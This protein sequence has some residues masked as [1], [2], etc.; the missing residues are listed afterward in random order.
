MSVY[1]WGQIPFV[2]LRRSN[3]S[4][5]P[6]A[7]DQNQYGTSGYSFTNTN[8]F[9]PTS[10]YFAAATSYFANINETGTS[11]KWLVTP[12]ISLTGDNLKLSL[13][14]MSGTSS[15]NYKDKFRVLFTTEPV[16]ETLNPTKFEAFTVRNTVLETDSV[17]NLAPTVPVRYEV[18]L[19]PSFA[20]NT[21]SF[22]VQ[23]VTGRVN[24]AAAGGDRLF[25]DN[26]QVTSGVATTPTYT[27]GATPVSEAVATGQ[28][29]VYPNPTSGLVNIQVPTDGS[30]IVS[31][32]DARGMEVASY[33]AS[34]YSFYVD[35]SS[36]NDGLYVV[37]VRN[38]N[39]TYSAK[40]LKN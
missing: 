36:L 22:A 23:L 33:R 15:G 31:I 37:R 24:P 18:A 9:E 35:L 10:N 12:P 17:V 27:C 39:S 19:P 25:V 6:L 30:S 20:G 26:I 11:S 14:V 32:L 21:V 5:T 34:G 7:V 28:L 8:P 40:V 2:I 4:I 3:N 29:K 38:N 1:P 16:G 13:E